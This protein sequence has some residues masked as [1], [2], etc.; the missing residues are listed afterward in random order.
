MSSVVDVKRIHNYIF[1]NA[2]LIISTYIYIYLA[3]FC[4]NPY[5]NDF[6][7]KNPATCLPHVKTA[8]SLLAPTMTLRHEAYW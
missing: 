2:F 6:C 7:T 5:A 3:M 1:F 8:L 4:T